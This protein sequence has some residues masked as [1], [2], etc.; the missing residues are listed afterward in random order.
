VE[1][2]F[3]VGEF[4][5]QDFG[6]TIGVLVTAGV[7]IKLFMSSQ[8]GRRACDTLVLKLPWVGNL[9]RSLPHRR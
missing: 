5:E 8:A 6:I 7:G 1:L 3:F 9:V 4:M 2:F